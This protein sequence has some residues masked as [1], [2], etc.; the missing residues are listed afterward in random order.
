M[1]TEYDKKEFIDLLI[2][3][4]A[5]MEG[6][7]NS[8]E[9]AKASKTSWPTLT[10]RNS[11]PIGLTVWGAFP[12][13]Q[14]MVR[15][16]KP[17]EGLEAAK[18]FITKNVFVRKVSF[19]EL[20]NGCERGADIY[21]GFRSVAQGYNAQQYADCLIQ[22]LCLKSKHVGNYQTLT[23]IDVSERTIIADLL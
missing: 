8:E 10:Q 5:T 9:D 20:F 18:Q 4:L 23:N 3:C 15:F 6:Y 14:G 19:Y 2:Q 16:N 1:Y 11:N 7:Y 13:N 17:Q 12:I 21:K 22:Y